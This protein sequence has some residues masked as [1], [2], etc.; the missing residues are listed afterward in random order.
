MSSRLRRRPSRRRFRRLLRLPWR[1]SSLRRSP[2]SPWCRLCSCRRSRLCPR[3]LL[4]WCSSSSPWRLLRRRR[5]RPRSARTALPRTRRAPESRARP[6]SVPVRGAARRRGRVSLGEQDDER[7]PWGCILRCQGLGGEGERVTGSTA[8]RGSRSCM[9]RGS[10]SRRPRLSPS[11][12]GC[13]APRSSPSC[14][15]KRGAAPCRR[16]CR[17]R[18]PGPDR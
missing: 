5:R 3:S 14:R 7:L 1:L 6:G 8:P 12:C 9:W 13:A 15:C 2:R 10:R 17:C 16:A 18:P 11:R 4:S